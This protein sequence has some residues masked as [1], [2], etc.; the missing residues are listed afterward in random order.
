MADTSTAVA[1]EALVTLGKEEID[2]F[3]EETAQELQTRAREYLDRIEQER[4]ARR[5]ELGVEDDM[6]QINGMTTAMM[7]ALGENDIKTLEDFADC[8]TDDLC[9][10]VERSKTASASW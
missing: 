2:G 7:V 6:A 5:R 10:W 8:A 9:G 3:D 4:D 1:N